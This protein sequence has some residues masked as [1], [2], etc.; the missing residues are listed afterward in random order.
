MS[1]AADS[2]VR[3]EVIAVTGASNYLGLGVMKLLA[4]D[5]SVDRIIAIDVKKPELEHPKL[6]YYKVDLTSPASQQ[7]LGK[8]FQNEHVS[9][10]LHLVFTY[11]L[12]RNRMLAH[13]LEAIG[14]M[15]V[16]DACS[17]ARVKRIVGR[18]T[19]AIYGA[20]RGNPNFLTEMHEPHDSRSETF[21]S[22]KLELER[23]FIQYGNTHDYTHVAILRDCTSLGATSINYL[24]RLLLSRR[25]PRVLGYN[26][27]MQFI[28]EQDLFRAYHMIIMGRSEGIY[29]IVGKGVVRY[30]EAIRRLGG[31]E[32]VLPESMLRAGTSV[33]WGLNMFD[34]PSTFIN[35]IKY[36]WVAD[37]TKAALKLDFVPEFDCFK[38]LEDAYLT[39][40]AKVA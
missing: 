11:T 16:L 29:N 28:H 22:D 35:H 40:L 6:V 25:T 24:S 27:L 39:R 15:H 12:S 26:P 17:H 32:L 21:I 9:R 18:S 14:T 19:T 31:G 13:E 7:I 33:L 36:S 5:S 20:K 2:V 4:E 30:S 38:A 34:V 37:G 10:L 8:I 3:K 23:Q 1:T